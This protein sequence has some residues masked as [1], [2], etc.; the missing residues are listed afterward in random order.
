MEVGVEVG[1][2][3]EAEVQVGV[4]AGGAGRLP[5]S[6]FALNCWKAVMEAWTGQK[7]V[8]GGPHVHAHVRACAC[9]HVAYI[10]GGR[11]CTCV[12]MCVCACMRTHT[13]TQT[14]V[15]LYTSPH[16]PMHARRVHGPLMQQ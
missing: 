13:H 6:C 16:V 12:C 4:E 11:R 2:E 8:R 7:G 9:V 3:G 14:H 1:V 5:D 10:E 15:Q